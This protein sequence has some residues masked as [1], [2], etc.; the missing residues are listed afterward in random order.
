[1][2]RFMHKK[3][4]PSAL[5]VALGV[6]LAGCGGSNHNG[7]ASAPP[8][9]PAAPAPTV[10][11][12]TPADGATGVL[13]T[14]EVSATFDQSMDTATLKNANFSVNCP[15]GAEPFGSVI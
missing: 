7:Q 5:S 11:T 13:N 6:G 1:M 14:A 10:V 8:T 15:A 2:S 4:L 9:P 12:V 3:W